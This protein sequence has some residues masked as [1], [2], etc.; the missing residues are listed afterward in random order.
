MSRSRASRDTGLSSSRNDRYG[1]R[2]G[3]AWPSI[4]ERAERRSNNKR[5]DEMASHLCD[6][7]DFLAITKTRQS[8]ETKFGGRSGFN[9][10]LPLANP[11][12]TTS[13]WA[14]RSLFSVDPFEAIDN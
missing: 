3:A 2:R 5:T 9:L 7:R 10:S 8:R 11:A 4:N 1:A 14:W 12:L 13:C 6:N